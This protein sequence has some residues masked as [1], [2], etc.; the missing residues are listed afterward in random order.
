LRGA[1]DSGAEGRVLVD[2]RDVDLEEVD[3]V[4]LEEG[5]V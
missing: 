4:V 3:L 2:G 5:V 1:Y